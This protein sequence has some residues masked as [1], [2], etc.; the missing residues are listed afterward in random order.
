MKIKSISRIIKQIK[1]TPFYIEFLVERVDEE[2][3]KYYYRN[4]IKN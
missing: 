1:K 2:D 3:K 4:N